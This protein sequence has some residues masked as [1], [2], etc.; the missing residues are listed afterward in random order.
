MLFAFMCHIWST[1]RAGQVRDRWRSAEVLRF[2]VSSA[3][4]QAADLG[5]ALDE[6]FAFGEEMA[7]LALDWSKSCDRVPLRVIE[8]LARRA[9]PGFGGP[10]SAL[11]PRRVVVWGIAAGAGVGPRLPGCDPVRGSIDAL[12]S[13]RC[14]GGGL[15]A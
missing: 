9:P 13:G 14:G 11:T 15:G 8:F 12:P 10:W 7:G 3:D 5:V 6:A 1:L 2:G 4:G